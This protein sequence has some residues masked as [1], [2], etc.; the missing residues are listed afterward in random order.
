MGE[1][2]KM[3]SEVVVVGYGTQ[4]KVNLTGSVA[5]VNLEKVFAQTNSYIMKNKV[6]RKELGQWMNS[7]RETIYGPLAERLKENC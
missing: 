3:L 7:C 6:I 4:K 5:T 2:V 1:N